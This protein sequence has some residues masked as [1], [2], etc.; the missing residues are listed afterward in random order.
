MNNSKPS[1]AS[2]MSGVGAATVRD[3]NAQEWS[4][5]VIDELQHIQVATPP[6][7]YIV[8]TRLSGS[9]GDKAHTHT[10]RPRQESSKP[11]GHNQRSTGQLDVPQR[12]QAGTMDSTATIDIVK[13]IPGGW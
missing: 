5:A 7:K 4:Q 3:L 12:P 2:G 1:S 9:T 13:Q 6:M 10:S 8:P 11:S